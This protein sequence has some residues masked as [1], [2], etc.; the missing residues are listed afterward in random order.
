MGSPPRKTNVVNPAFPD[1]H[2]VAPKEEEILD[3]PSP[4]QNWGS[5]GGLRSIWNDSSITTTPLAPPQGHDD[6]MH[7]LQEDDHKRRASL[8]PENLMPS[9]QPRKF[10]L[11]TA[12]EVDYEALR[13]EGD[14]FSSPYAPSKTRSRS[15]SSGAIFSPFNMSGLAAAVEEEQPPSLWGGDES[16]RRRSVT[17]PGI[18][19]GIM[20]DPSTQ[21]ENDANNLALP[22]SVGLGGGYQMTDRRFSH[23]PNLHSNLLKEYVLLL[24]NPQ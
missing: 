22:T 24:S 14:I 13:V 19:F 15:K 17:Q 2:F 10:S 6:S 8:R 7:R 18:P 11:T 16:G 12:R 21:R 23:A 20:W 1:F 9:H 5:L 3:A 4:A